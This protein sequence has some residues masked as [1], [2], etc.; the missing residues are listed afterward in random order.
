M[1]QGGSK[2]EFPAFPS[3]VPGAKKRRPTT[4]LLWEV[5]YFL[6]R[7]TFSLLLRGIFFLLLRGVFFLLLRG[8]FFSLAGSG[9]PGEGVQQ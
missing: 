4:E 3:V 1:P 7:G 8:T 9:A 6:L 5:L 2:S